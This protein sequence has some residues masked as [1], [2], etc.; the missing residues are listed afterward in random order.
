MKDW[1]HKECVPFSVE[2]QR[3]IIMIKGDYALLLSVIVNFRPSKF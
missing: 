3:Y 1:M 2:A